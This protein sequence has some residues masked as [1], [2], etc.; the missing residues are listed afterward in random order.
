LRKLADRGGY[1]GVMEYLDVPG[2]HSAGSDIPSWS[3]DSKWVYYTAKVGKAVEL[4]RVSLAGHVEQLTHSAPGVFHYN[5][6]VSPEG[7]WVMF[8]ST[9]DGVRQL[10]VA[11]ADGQS[12]RPVTSLTKGR[13]AYSASWQTGP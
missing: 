11:A 10:W 9:R 5:P 2:F 6:K 13:A 4:M 7:T 1:A 12:A 8:G 3:P